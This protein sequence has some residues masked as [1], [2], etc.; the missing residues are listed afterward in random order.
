[1]PES[2]ETIAKK[3]DY[4]KIIIPLILGLSVAGYLLFNSLNE[5]KYTEVENFTTDQFIMNGRKTLWLLYNVQAELDSLMQTG[6][7][8]AY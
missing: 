5:V 3:L 8:L 4:H 1:M 6:D 2:S 7:T